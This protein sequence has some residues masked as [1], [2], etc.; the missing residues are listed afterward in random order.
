MRLL[1]A[2]LCLLIG[3]ASPLA[4]QE[5]RTPRI[6]GKPLAEWERM[7]QSKDEAERLRAVRCLGYLGP[8]AHEAV[9]A[10]CHLVND[11]DEQVR[12]EAY[13]TLLEMGPHAR[14]AIPALIGQLKEAPIIESVCILRVL[15]DIGL[16]A[17]TAAKEILPLALDSNKHFG[18]RQEALELLAQMGPKA[19]FVSND[20]E[21]LL[22]DPSPMTRIHAAQAVWKIRRDKRAIPILLHVLQDKKPTETVTSAMRLNSVMRSQLESGMARML[23]PNMLGEIGPDAGA[24]VVDLRKR[25]AEE[26]DLPG[27]TCVAL[28][29]IAKDQQAIDMLLRRLDS[30]ERGEAFIALATILK[31]GPEAKPAVPWLTRRLET[32]VAYDRTIAAIALWKIEKNLKAR[33]IL[34]QSM[35]D[36]DTTILLVWWL[37]SDGLGNEIRPALGVL[38]KH[39]HD[40]SASDDVRY[41]AARWI[42]QV[43]PQFAEKVGIR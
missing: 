17:E 40:K 25:M 28:W 14:E 34:L 1:T 11:A 15:R 7:L 23:V 10:L 4:G 31:L 36:K 3:V 30:T 32:S 9:P 37:G 5:K 18:V 16:P 13:R 6:G 29:R 12:T 43:D 38:L 21:K 20:L 33:G 41:Y 27:A 26:D 22:N 19:E 35:S 42:T 2:C 39:Y 24:A 8:V